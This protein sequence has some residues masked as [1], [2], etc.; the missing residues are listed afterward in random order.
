M[1]H[2][3]VLAEESIAGLAIKADGIY[4][5][6]TYGGGGHTKRILEKLTTGKLYAFD[7]DSD[8]W[9]NLTDNE[10]LTLIRS[11]FKYLKNFL[12]YYNAIPC[13]GIL[14]D[15]GVSSHQFDNADRGFS[16]RYDA[17]LDMRM[18]RSQ[19]KSALDIINDYK[20]DALQNIFSLYGE[21][22]NARTLSNKIVEARAFKTIQT[23]SDF[24]KAIQS[25]IP[26][27]NEPQYMAQ[28]FQSIRIEV[29]Q[30]LES[31]KQF[32]MQCAAVLEK[33]GRLVV[34]SYH[35]LE[36]RLVKNFIAKGN[37]E[38]TSETDLFGVEKSA[39]LKPI[40]KKPI[41]ASTEELEK[42]PRA[43]SARMRIAEKK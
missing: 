29:N 41:E 24:K 35:S 15:L 18:N 1:Y 38:A 40:N 14:A 28:V 4:V 36:D 30:E 9:K 42:N 37:F 3:P 31:L 10:R 5:D 7:Q 21:V 11:N 22:S 12:H 2:D 23:L 13:H 27:G 8:A 26:S 33:G 25:C 32:L 16:I 17:T 34:I 39:V 43:R 19:E 6:A 20:A